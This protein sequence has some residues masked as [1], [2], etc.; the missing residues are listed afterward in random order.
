MSLKLKITVFV[1]NTLLCV[2]I[3]LI[4]GL[5]MSGWGA[6]VKAACY[7]AAGAGFLAALIFFIINK[8]SLFKSV[9]VLVICAFVLIAVIAVFSAVWHLNEYATDEEKIAAL[10]SKIEGIGVWGM[11]VFFLIQILQVVILP[12]PAALCYVPGSIIWGPLIATLIASAGVIAGSLIS[13]FIGKFFGKRAVEWIAGKETCEKYSAYLNKRGKV[14]FVLMQILPFFPDDILCMIAGL[15]CMNFPFFLLTIVIVRPILIATYCYLGSGTVIPFN[16]PWGIAVW[17][18]IFAVCIALAILSLKYQ[19]RLENRLVE[20]FSKRK[21]TNP[22]EETAE[23]D[24][25]K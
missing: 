11:A 4:T 3:A 8:P 16:E 13:Y 21:K 14:I 15:T 19:E 23:D 5:L 7:A 18:V 1:I 10:V 24:E 25:Q 17:V 9:F 6:L 2:G 12:I 20:K 22:A